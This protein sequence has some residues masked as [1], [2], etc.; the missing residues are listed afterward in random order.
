MWERYIELLN[1]HCKH[2][3][4]FL[5]YRLILLLDNISASLFF[6]VEQL[7]KWRNRG[8]R[9][10]DA[11]PWP[12]SLMITYMWKGK[13]AERFTNGN[14]VIFTSWCTTRCHPPWS[15]G[16]CWA[17]SCCVPLTSFHYGKRYLESRS[18]LPLGYLTGELSWVL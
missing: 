1:M 9:K 16:V 7:L 6:I 3:F 13:R 14:T 12:I 8:S 4:P 2:F 17:W 18:Y 5:S 15:S 11:L 10:P